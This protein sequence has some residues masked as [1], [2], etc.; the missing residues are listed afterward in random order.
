MRG[1]LLLVWL[2]LAGPACGQGLPPTEAPR[3]HALYLELGGKSPFYSLNYERTL[4]QRPRAA[5]SLSLGLGVTGD[6]LTVPLG[7][8]VLTG[9]GTHHAEFSLGLTPGIRHYAAANTDKVGYL[10][11]GIGYRY[12]LPAGGLFWGIGF[13]PVVFIDP[14]S[15]DPWA[16]SSRLY[17]SGRVSLGWRW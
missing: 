9:S 15:S 4:W 7:V 13:T 1:Q 6:E 16:F 8:A 5:Y 17:P 12:Q 10:V 14:P 3:R 2:G 11:P